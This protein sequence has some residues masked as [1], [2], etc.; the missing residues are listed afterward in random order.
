MSLGMRA[1]PASLAS[2]LQQRVVTS[3]VR[4]WESGQQPAP[5]LPAM[6]TVPVLPSGHQGGTSGP[7]AAAAAGFGNWLDLQTLLRQ[8]SLSYQPDH[9]S[10]SADD[11]EQS[12]QAQRSSVLPSMPAG[13][14]LR[15]LPFR[16]AQRVTELEAAVQ[17]PSASEAA[18]QTQAQAQ[19]QSLGNGRAPVA[20]EASVMPRMYSMLKRGSSQALQS[21]LLRHTPAVPTS[22]G[23]PL[24]AVTSGPAGSIPQPGQ[25]ASHH[26]SRVDGAAPASANG[27]THIHI[28]TD[29][30]PDDE[31]SR[32]AIPY[33]VGV[34][35]AGPLKAARERGIT[36]PLTNDNVAEQRNGY[37]DTTCPTS[38][39]QP[40]S[41][42]DAQMARSALLPAA[43]PDLA[44]EIQD[45]EGK[46]AAQAADPQAG[47]TPPIAGGVPGEAHAHATKANG[48]QHDDG[49]QEQ[50][51][52]VRT[53][54]GEDE[55]DDKAV[56]SV[57]EMPIT[58][59]QS[60]ILARAESGKST[61]EVPARKSRRTTQRP[62][63]FS[64]L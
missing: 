8:A 62:K 6:A 42:A 2:A 50:Q 7:P 39:V 54:G 49:L 5:A 35:T 52:D 13:C 22:S 60:S 47:A 19:P 43:T 10:L 11:P 33:R 55:P 48:R 40:N 23:K 24:S 63:E 46:E 56:P 45:S 12:G 31:D 61:K 59:E 14:R 21:Q 64:L 38:A 32:P 34:K 53:A 26:S 1:Q 16:P 27:D 29:Q 25:T 41:A 58:M 20:A 4:Q 44:E 36:L 51:S 3:G 28:M 57:S 18:H 9:P 37:S 17:Q 15:S 30:Q